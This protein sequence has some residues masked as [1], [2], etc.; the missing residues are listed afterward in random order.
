MPAPVIDRAPITHAPPPVQSRPAARTVL[1]V[2]DVHQGYGATEVLRGISFSLAEG[3]IGCLLGPSGCGKTTLLRCIAGFEPIAAGEIRID[4]RVVSSRA[5]VVPPE[6]RRIG[7]VFQDYALFPHLDA[8]DNVAF[9]LRKLGKGE[10]RARAEEL[11]AA[12]GLADI[13]RRFPHE[14]SGGQQQR[15]ALARALAPAPSLLLLD[16]P[17]SNLDVELR[18]RLSLEIRDIIKKSGTTAIL[19]THD[20]HEAFAIADEIGI[21]T[22]GRIQQWDS[23][24]NLYHRPATRFIADFVGQGVFL[25]G[26][27]VSPQELRIELGSIGGEIPPLCSMGCDT[28]GKGCAIDVLLR[29]DDVVHDD[30][31]PLKAEVVQ[32]AFR[33]AEFLYTLRLASGRKVLALV[34]SHHNHAVGEHIGIRLAVD[35]VV[36]FAPR[37]RDAVGH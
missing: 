23:A 11:L 37:D 9:G 13:A 3:S 29:P 1:A 14:L 15:V 4:D 31:S 19:V 17:F 25:P 6:E 12:V 32:K 22:D 28:C 18:E 10:R 27:V 30:A 35:H 24:Y 8:L 5:R 2:D 36:A 21:V 16:E 34:P 7:M 26:A 20:Q 33:G